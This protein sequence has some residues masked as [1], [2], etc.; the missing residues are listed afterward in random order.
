[1]SAVVDLSAEPWPSLADSPALTAAVGAPIAA[2]ARRV[3]HVLERDGILVTLGFAGLTEIPPDRF[4]SHLDALVLVGGGHDAEGERAGRPR[5][6]PRH[7]AAT[8]G[9]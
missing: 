8:V 6:G 7:D 1:M 9:G 2:Q 4:A 3:M 5:R